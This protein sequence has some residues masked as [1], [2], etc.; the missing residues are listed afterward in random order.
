MPAA[1]EAA[2]RGAYKASDAERLA[3]VAPRTPGWPPWPQQPEPKPAA[4]ESSEEAT[5][6]PDHAEYRTK[7][8]W[9]QEPELWKFCKNSKDD[10]K[11]ANL[12][13]G[14]FDTAADAHVAFL[15]GNDV[16]RGYGKL[17]GFVVKAE[18]VDGLGD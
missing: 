10:D 5:S 16:S 2:S 17:Y 6:D 13:V 8:G 3:E 14:V 12:V 4:S 9:H 11:L 1:A 18:E 15:A 7:D